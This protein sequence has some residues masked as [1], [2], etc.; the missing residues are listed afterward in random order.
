MRATRKRLRVSRVARETGRDRAVKSTG[1]SPSLPGLLSGIVQSTRRHSPRRKTATRIGISACRH[2][3]ATGTVSL[4][5]TCGIE[6]K[7]QTEDEMTTPGEQFIELSADAPTLCLSFGGVL[8]MGHGSIDDD[9]RRALDS[10]R[11]LFDLAPYLVEVLAPRPLVQIV[12][13]TSWLQTL[14]AEKTAALLPDE[15]R[16]RVVGTTLGTPPRLSEIRDGSARAWILIRHARK[17]GVTR[18]LPLDDEAWGV[19]LGL[20]QH[21][22]HTKSELALGVPE[23][24]QQLEA[25]L[26]VNGRA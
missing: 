13:S 26:A 7:A 10:G 19:P 25:W 16:G 2:R 14:G 18:W 15:L 9:G 22:L 21:F 20:E 8:N 1:T 3:C 23:A 11:S 4:G 5:H 6:E 17:I 24:T 12:L